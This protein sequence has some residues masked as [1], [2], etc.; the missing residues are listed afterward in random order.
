MKKL[1]IALIILVVSC[2]IL[3]LIGLGVFYYLY[4]QGQI[5]LDDLNQ[6]VNQQ[7]N[8]NTET[9][10]NTN[11]NENVNTST[12]ETTTESNFASWTGIASSVTPA[13]A[14]YAAAA[15]L[16]DVGNT[17][18]VEYFS[19]DTKVQLVENNFIVTPAQHNEFF[20][21]YEEN[22]YQYTP[23]F[24]TTDSVL[25]TYHLYFNYLLENVENEFLMAEAES[26]SQA[27]LDKSVEQYNELKGTEWEDAALHNIGFFNVGLKLLKPDAEVNSLVADK[28]NEELGYIDEHAGITDSPLWDYEIKEDYSQYIPRGHYDKTDE[29]KRY[30]K[31]MMWYGRLSFRIK[32]AGEVKSSVLMSKALED[33]T[34]YTSWD[35]IYEPTNFFVGKSD[36]IDNYTFAPAV[37]EV[38]GEDYSLTDLQDNTKF[39]ALHD[40]LKLLE[41]P[42]INSMPVMAADAGGNEDLEE[43]IKSFRFMGQRYTIDADVFQ[44]LIYR[45]VDKNEDDEKRMLPKALDIPAA[46]GSEEAYELLDDAGDTE[47]ENYIE[48][49]DGMSKYLA[50]LENEVWT[51]NLYWSWMYTLLPLVEEKD[52]GYPSFM[53]NQAWT[54]KQL[55]TYISSWTEL[56][57]DTILYAKQV[58]AEMGAGPITEKDDRGYVEPEPELYARMSALAQLTSDGLDSRGLLTEN[59]KTNLATFKELVDNLQTIAEKELSGESLTDADYELIRGYGGSLEHLWLETM[60]EEEKGDKYKDELLVDN[61]APLVA[62]VATDPNGTVLEEATGYIDEIYVIVP[63]EGNLKIAKG[64]VYSHYEFTQPLAERLTDT[65]WREK[66][67]AGEA[68][69]RAEWH[70]SFF[71]ET[72]YDY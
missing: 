62:D 31:C 36:D 53:T 15:D 50:N 49:M 69:E 46:M 58:Y 41:G 71:V 43:E 26:L 59:D 27:M 33:A 3:V 13:V 7:T 72:P 38:F 60:S 40:K 11:Q 2:L 20:S 23:N 32:D 14:S 10:E 45:L 35:K 44:N 65:Q 47:Y 24:I 51:Q 56:K 4:T 19:D 34:I 64:G 66:L 25:H 63:V 6:N 37:V 29:L 39:S 55:M 52:E 54:R 28:V 21:V 16:S 18:T 67:S 8:V 61:P 22:R 17:D 30:F 48:N 70:E 12:T 42:A 9:N 1:I 57:H 68:P 5:S